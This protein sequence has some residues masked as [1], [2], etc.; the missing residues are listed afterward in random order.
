[1]A[2]VKTFHYTLIV[3]P[4]DYPEW[5]IDFHGQTSRSALRA[6][7]RRWAQEHLLPGTPFELRYDGFT[8]I[9]DPL[10]APEAQRYYQPLVAA[11]L[12]SQGDLSHYAYVERWEG[13]RWVRECA[14]CSGDILA[15]VAAD[16]TREGHTIRIQSCQGHTLAS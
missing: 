9:P 2:R 16:L 10:D 7:A 15:L 4:A 6:R 3:R 5:T 11:G 13:T 14:T 12:D 1:M 8:A